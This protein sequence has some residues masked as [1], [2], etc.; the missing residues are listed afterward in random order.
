MTRNRNFCLCDHS[1]GSGGLVLPVGC[2]LLGQTVVTGKSVDSALDKD[3]SE[4]GVLVLLVAVKMLAHGNSLL[5]EHVKV[6]GDLRGEGV[7]LQDS[8]DLV[9]GH[10]S[11]LGD[12]VGVTKDDT[13]LVTTEHNTDE[14]LVNT[15]DIRYSAAAMITK[16]MR[17]N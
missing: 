11:H 17:V 8:E 3:Q 15:I 13:N 2:E 4:L 5:D 1:G 14:I 9:S 7:L 16:A 12:T 10:A 6:L